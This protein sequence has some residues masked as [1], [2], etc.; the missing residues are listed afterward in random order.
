[1]MSSLNK[2][3]LIGNL[4]Q[5][6]NVYRNTGKAPCARF[7]LAT[8]EQWLNKHQQKVAHT[9]WHQLVAYNR[10]AEIAE[11]YFDKGAKLYIEGKL[12]THQWQDK[13]GISRTTTVIVVETFKFLSKKPESEQ[14]NTQT[15]NN[16]STH[17]DND[18]G[19]N[20][21]TVAGVDIDLDVDMD[22]NM[23][24]GTNS[25]ANDYPH[26]TT[27]PIAEDDLPF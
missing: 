7:S 20:A 9:E 22:T 19:A 17:A 26:T 16:N 23:N 4:G 6:P 14:S 5:K 1:M 3:A 18:T 8:T 2:V 10:L 15:D 13:Q 27:A 11:Q 25:R 12:R 21:S 24:M